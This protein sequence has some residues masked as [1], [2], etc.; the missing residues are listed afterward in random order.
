MANI[1]VDN[2]TGLCLRCGHD[3]GRGKDFCCDACRS[4]WHRA[5]R[6]ALRE[7]GLLKPHVNGNDEPL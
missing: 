5:A 6:I 2:K 3:L 4:A 1:K 7:S